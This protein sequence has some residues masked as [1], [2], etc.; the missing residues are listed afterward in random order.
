MR[1]WLAIV[2]VSILP[3]AAEAQQVAVR[4]GD[5]DGFTRL[6]F[7]LPSRVGW[8]LENGEKQAVLRLDSNGLSF[9]TSTVFERIQRDRLDDLVIDRKTQTVALRFA[10]DCTAQGFWFKRSMLVI[11]VTQTDSDDPDAMIDTGYLPREPNEA[12]QPGSALQLPTRTYSPATTLVQNALGF[13]SPLGPPASASPIHGDV[14]HGVELAESRDRLLRQLSRATSQ[15]LLAP[16]PVLAPRPSVKS[17]LNDHADQ[18]AEIAEASP[19]PV[20]T[21]PT[22]NLHIKVL[23]S[24][25]RDFLD[26][27]EARENEVLSGGC[28][29]GKLLDVGAWGTDDP[30]WDQVGPL[31]SRMTS[32]FDRTDEKTVG[33]LA[34]VYLYFGFG[35]EAGQIVELLPQDRETT[36]VY[37]ALAR[38]MDAGSADGSLLDDQLE[39]DAPGA[40]WSALS[41]TR[42]PRDARLDTDGMLRAF[43]ALPRHLRTHLGPTLSARLL[44]AGHKRESAAIL[45]VLDRVEE[46]KT[47]AADLV[48]ADLEMEKGQPDVAER[49]LQTVV[50]SNGVLSPNALVRQIDSRIEQGGEVSFDLA[51]LASAYAYEHAGTPLGA[52]LERSHILALGGSGAFDDAFSELHRLQTDTG[53]EFASVRAELTARLASHAEPIELLKHVLAGKTA[54][55]ADLPQE[56]SLE[57][58]DE[59]ATAGFHGQALMALERSFHGKNARRA[60]LLRANASLELGQ[61][62]QAEVELL[63]LDGQ[64]VNGLRARA[65]SMVGEHGQAYELFKSAGL[66]DEASREAWLANDGTVSD[67]ANTSP[68]TLESAE[69]AG[70]VL[71]RN[72]ALL[73]GAGNTR[74][75]LQA[76]LSEAPVL[77]SEN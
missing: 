56:T 20:Q 23:T 39:C 61:P 55:P 57:I 38:I 13:E 28:L 69:P 44:A 4:S 50:E 19:A 36:K 71:E 17:T 45:R 26:A 63:G 49:F 16:K 6:V 12:N 2:L 24:I 43:S 35:L 65:R 29:D 54:P 32:E 9:D 25:D 15:G 70:G 31:R 48:A 3:G 58:A 8:S 42:L 7:N 64:D 46:T 18:P 52:E 73:E 77:G 41:H 27:L 72:K 1:S 67:G 40:M 14:R 76:L 75:S 11:D 68:D 37:R 60:R 66:E 22:S 59:L 5:H 30:F 10:C 74:A 53:A 62:R 21:Q 34:R 51:Q 33:E 47:P